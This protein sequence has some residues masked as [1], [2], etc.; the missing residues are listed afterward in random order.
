M[1]IMDMPS[2]IIRYEN[3][4]L[5]EEEENEFFQELVNSGM[6]W[7]LQGHYGRRAV[8]MLMNGEIAPRYTDEMNAVS[9]G[10]SSSW[11]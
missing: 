9:L 7:K 3:G 6:A 8:D 11:S 2:Q 4:E 5:T 10:V 1:M